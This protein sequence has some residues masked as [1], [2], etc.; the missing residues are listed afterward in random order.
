MEKNIIMKHYNITSAFTLIEVI[1]AMTIFG[2]IMISVLSIFLFSSQMSSRVEIN[3]IM[4][5]NIKNITEDIS[6][7]IRKK[8]LSW[9][10]ADGWFDSCNSWSGSSLVWTKLCL[11]W[12]I[13]YS[14]W[15]ATGATLSW[16]RVNDI[17]TCQD[18]NSQCH[19][20]KRDTPSEDYYPLTNSFSHFE[21]IS[22]VIT[23][24]DIPKLSLHMSLRASVN[25]GLSSQVVTN[26]LTHIQTTISERLITTR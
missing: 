6:E 16:Q 24:T 11:E 4:Q 21:D 2:I 20:I 26:S 1:V 23:N 14:I 8:W 3:R 5:E 7:N 15:H 22:F 10:L 18:I 12:W 25:K 17:S 13:E 9:V 19:I